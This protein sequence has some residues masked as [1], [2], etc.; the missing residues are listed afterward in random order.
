MPISSEFTRTSE[1]EQ[2]AIQAT[3]IRIRI[4]LRRPQRSPPSSSFP[5]SSTTVIRRNRQLKWMVSRTIARKKILVQS[6]EASE[7]I[8]SS[9]LVFFSLFLLNGRENQGFERNGGRVCF[10]GKSRRNLRP[11]GLAGERGN[12][13]GEITLFGSHGKHFFFLFSDFWNS[14]VSVSFPFRLLLL[15]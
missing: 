5:S 13:E 14:T 6:N 11:S 1:E 3:V 8:L 2:L 15:F 10:S 9:V 7:S 4:Y 12:V